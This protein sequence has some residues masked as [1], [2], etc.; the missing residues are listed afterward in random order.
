MGAIMVDR[1]SGSDLDHLVFGAR[2]HINNEPYLAVQAVD[3]RPMTTRL[4][5]GEFDGDRRHGMMVASR[6]SHEREC[7]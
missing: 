5:Q 6:R 7:A 3:S 4:V 2:L 1:N